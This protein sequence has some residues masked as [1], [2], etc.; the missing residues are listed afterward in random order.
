MRDTRASAW[1]K[2]NPVVSLT[3]LAEQIYLEASLSPDFRVLE[4][5]P[6][7]ESTVPPEAVMDQES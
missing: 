1:E 4:A 7:S 2:L 3:P 5:P 6:V